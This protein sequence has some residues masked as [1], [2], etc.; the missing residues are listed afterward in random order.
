MTERDRDDTHTPDGNA[1]TDDH[2][3]EEDSIFD[4]PSSADAGEID[5]QTR[6]PGEAT[7]EEDKNLDLE[8][9]RAVSSGE[10]LGRYAVWPFVAIMSLLFGIARGITT[11]VVARVPKRSTLYKKMIKGSFKQLYKRSNAHV[12]CCTIYGDGEM[13]PRI[14]KHDKETGKLETKNGEWWTASSG[15]NP[16]FVGDT[17][18]V[19]GVADDH[20][21]IDPVAARIA[22]AV[23]LGPHRYT[24][25]SETREGFAP[26]VRNGRGAGTGA[27]AGAVAD[28]GH[29]PHIP[30]SF[31]DVWLDAS[32][33][34][35]ENDGWIISLEKAY[36]MHWDKG[37]SEEMENQETRGM[38]AVMDP[39]GDTKKALIFVLLFAGGIALG[40][41]GPALASSI[42]GGDGGGSAIPLVLGALGVV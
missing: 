17:P 33:P 30:C 28:G 29:E 18:V 7:D 36:E 6:Q 26:G 5:W 8:N 3:L 15:L 11:A 14:A 25:V 4:D 39:R 38:L 34:E 12:I 9:E 16:I 22:E 23:D 37:S 41:F 42:A 31:D 20:E 24:E 35:P 13:V 1:P 32:N 27:G 21:L 40:L 10:T 2:D 19:F